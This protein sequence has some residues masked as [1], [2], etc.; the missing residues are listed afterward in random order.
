MVL[1]L[2]IPKKNPGA[3]LCLFFVLIFVMDLGIFGVKSLSM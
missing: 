3:F 2:G 1:G